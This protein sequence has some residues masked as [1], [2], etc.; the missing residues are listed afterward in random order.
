MQICQLELQEKEANE[1]DLVQEED[2]NDKSFQVV[3]LT[4]MCYFLQIGT[5]VISIRKRENYWETGRAFFFSNTG[6]FLDWETARDA[7]R[8]G[9]KGS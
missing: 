3:S 2:S 4:Y 8:S 7:L 6:C 5:M 9:A 1:N